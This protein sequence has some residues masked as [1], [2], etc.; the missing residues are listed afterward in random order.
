MLVPC[1]AITAVVALL[2]GPSLGSLLFPPRDDLTFF[3]DAGTVPKPTE[4]ARYL[5]ALA[6]AVLLV[7][8]IVAAVRRRP[9]LGPRA[10][11]VA[12]AAAQLATVGLL[13]AAAI[14]Q[15]R[16]SFTT[17][18]FNARTLVI[19]AVLAVAVVACVRNGRLAALAARALRD[20][21]PRRIA[22]LLVAAIVTAAY[23]LTAINTDRSFTWAED[24]YHATFALDE[25]F[26]VING[27]T[28]LADFTTQYAS[29]WPYAGALSMLAFGKTLLVFT[30]TM[31][32]IT[33]VSLLALFGVLRRATRSSTAALL[34]FLPLVATGFFIVRGTYANRF[35]FAGYFAAFPLRYA[36]PYLLA[37]LTARRLD[38]GEQVRAWPLFA[39]AG[40]VAVNN[41]DFGMAAFGASAGAMVWTMPVRDRQAL[42]RLAR[43]V[44]V[45]LI[46]ALAL[47]TTLTLVRSGS[48]P[49]LGRLFAYADLYGR[50]GFNAIPMPGVL[51]LPL[52]IYLTYVAA[53]A[54]ATVRAI[55]REPNRV[56]TGMLLWSGL[57]GLGSASYYVA[58]SHF[59]TLPFM[60]SP[61]ALAVALLAIVAVQRLRVAPRPTLASLTVLFGLGVMAC[62]LAQTPT[63]WSQIERIQTVP[64]KWR[65]LPEIGPAEVY[66]DPAMRRFISTIPDASGRLQVVRG[67]PVALFMTNGHRV[68]DAYGL[69]NVVPNT[70]LASIHTV[71]ALE[72]TLEAIRREGARTI[73]I[74]ASGSGEL[75]LTLVRN[76]YRMLTS[77]GRLRPVTG[78]GSLP[79]VPNFLL[80][81]NLTKWVDIR[82]VDPQLRL[83]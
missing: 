56:L 27:F 13:I 48:L 76:G 9:L 47:V 77:E 41:V 64:A 12:V 74:P 34:L 58:R 63:P 14:G 65:P 72:A 1:A 31:C 32:A 43:D 26:A 17:A 6:G 24:P 4:Q 37:W 36:G 78:D 33:L 22:A 40:V 75:Y 46:V 71:E 8:A 10:T 80:V 20:S 28:P 18:Y 25:A 39:A 16:A 61:W 82:R 70:G 15:R 7:I 3:P 68:A 19:A 38:R 69:K 30:I 49:E 53:V 2:L 11:A 73:I 55:A 60:F 54:A 62:S 66:R 23:L 57:F 79:G 29:L 45:G 52:I 21:R 44:G 50:A 42:L 83:R 35:S 81:E 5:I 51:G 59:E 67:A